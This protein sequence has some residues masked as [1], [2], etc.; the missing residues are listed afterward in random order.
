[1]LQELVLKL[2]NIQGMR[3]HCPFMISV[4]MYRLFLSVSFWDYSWVLLEH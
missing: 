1:M 3:E 2:T 4:A